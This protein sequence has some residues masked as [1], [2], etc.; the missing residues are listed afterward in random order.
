MLLAATIALAVTPTADASAADLPAT[1]S[2]T[3]LAADPAPV[4]NPSPSVPGI[5]LGP[6]APTDPVTAPPAAT[7][8]GKTSGSDDDP[9]W[10]DIPGQ[11]KKAIDDFF[12]GL[13]KDALNPVLA[14]LGHTLLATPDVTTMARVGQIWTGMAVLANSL[15]ILFVLA[16]AVVIMTHETLQTRYAAK[17][18]IP[19]LI[20][21]FIAGNA[22]LAL[23]GLV[24]HVANIVSA[25]I[26]G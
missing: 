4:P 3:V 19:R 9:S 26:M 5:G 15:Y 16:G 23:F 17:Q 25:G 22:S 21:G 24:I 7:A 11:I 2:A 14:L 10:Y 6:G 8:P 12:A 13:V 1:S 20:F 18:I